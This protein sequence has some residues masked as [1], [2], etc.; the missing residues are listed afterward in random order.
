MIWHYYSVIKKGLAIPVSGSEK[1][2]VIRRAFYIQLCPVEEGFVAT[3]P[4]TDIYE[5][6]SSVDNA[7]RSYLYSLADEFL[8]F[9]TRGKNLSESMLDQFHSIQSYVSIV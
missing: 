6:E 5:Q 1:K 7:V 2:I 8:W 4:I 9:E 3:S